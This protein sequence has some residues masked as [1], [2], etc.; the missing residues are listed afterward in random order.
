[1]GN[2]IGIGLVYIDGK[3]E[4]EIRVA[5]LMLGPN[6]SVHGDIHCQ[7]LYVM[8]SASIEGNLNVCPDLELPAGSEKSIVDQIPSSPASKSSNPA[9]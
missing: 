7:K 1:M 8:G 5:K 4:G 9:V 3:V 2:I 6:A